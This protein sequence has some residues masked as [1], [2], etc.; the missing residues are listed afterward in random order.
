VTDAIAPPEGFDLNALRS[1]TLR[2]RLT[3]DYIVCEGEIAM[4]QAKTGTAK[5]PAPIVVTEQRSG[6]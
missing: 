3:A 2:R 1:A 6:R 5:R 4:S